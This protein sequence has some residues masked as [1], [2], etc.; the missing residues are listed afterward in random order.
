MPQINILNIL[1]GDNQSNIVDKINYNFDQILSAGGGPQGQQGLIGPTGPIGPQ[2]PQGPQGLQGPSGTKWFVQDSSP[3]SGAVTGSNPWTY[4]SIGDYWLDPDSADQDVYVFTAT[5]WTYTGYGLAAGQLF[6][7][8]SPVNFNGGVTGQAILIAGTASP[9]AVVLSDSNINGITGYVPSGTGIDNINYENSKLKIATRNDR[10]KIISFSH[11]EFDV[12]NTSGG[13]ST[14]GNYT[15]NPSIDWDA[16]S[17]IS[18]SFYDI[19]F[20]NPTGAISI[21]S[22]G[23]VNGGINLFANQEISAQSAS[24]NIILKTS[25]T[26][27]G[28]FV[29]AS[30]VGGFLELSNNSPTPVNQANAPLFANSTGVGLGLGTG[31]FTQTGTDSRRLAVKGNTTISK[32]NGY[33]TQA[34]FTGTDAGTLYVEGNVGVG[35]FT[36]PTGS[37][38]GVATTGPAESVGVF[39]LLYVTANQPGPVSQFKHSLSVKGR[40]GRTVIGGGSYDFAAGNPVAGNSSD[41]SQEIYW[42]GGLFGGIYAAGPLLSYQ[43]KITSNTNTTAGA[44]VFGITTYT[45]AGAYSVDS[46]ANKTTI[47]TVNSNRLLE[48]QANS[49]S[50]TGYNNNLVAIGTN[51]YTKLGV[52]GGSTGQQYGTVSIGIDS[53]TVSGMRTAILN[54]YQ[55]TFLAPASPSPGDTYYQNYQTDDHSLYVLGY[56]TIGA[57]DTISMFTNTYNPS[58]RPYGYNTKLKIHR[59]LGSYITFSKGQNDVDGSYPG[60]YSNGLEI[61]S[62]ISL[63]PG[64]GKPSFAI[65][66][67]AVSSIDYQVV[68]GNNQRSFANPTG[69]F[70]SDTGE[71]VAIGASL[72]SAALN[73]SGPGGARAIN[74]T[75]DV[76]VNEGVLENYI[77][78]TT[79]INSPSFF[80]GYQFSNKLIVVPGVSSGAYNGNVLSGDVFLGSTDGIYAPLTIGAQNGGGMRFYDDGTRNVAHTIDVLRTDTD[81]TTGTNTPGWVYYDLFDS[82]IRAEQQTSGNWTN[83]PA[84]SYVGSPNLFDR[85]HLSYKIIGKTV[86]FKLQAVIGASGWG[87][88]TRAYAVRI[89]PVLQPLIKNYYTVPVGN[90][91]GTASSD[92]TGWSSANRFSELGVVRVAIRKFNSAPFANSWVFYIESALNQGQPINYTAD[93]WAGAAIRF[94]TTAELI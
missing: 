81:I 48:I 22:L 66:V 72:G 41:V 25:A 54:D 18:S 35:P 24:E 88:N 79:P 43:H 33:H 45:N 42:S 37:P 86:F 12:V 7:K 4:P 39:P 74:A 52:W 82:E 84:L 63:I 77:L 58:S 70:V 92:G 83:G 44:P 30:N 56:Q 50:P 40:A 3:A 60:D 2:G 17:P 14:T 51:N 6:Q 53:A 87:L 73:V 20:Q 5:G 8:I 57:P 13:A 69:F 75:G 78:P 1:Q 64:G 27:K 9:Q 28:T 47:Q 26:N 36:T 61:T 76:R 23:S 67:G 90:V 19:T 68:P 46:I 49:S 11:S 21:R 10:T 55:T 38:L 62:L 89:P 31:Q 59:N 85:P 29:D 32:N 15:W 65:A 80:S 34:L 93:W 16:S 71:N 94:E 91:I